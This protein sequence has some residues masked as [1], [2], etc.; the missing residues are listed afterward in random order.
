MLSCRDVFLVF[1]NEPK[2][3]EAVLVGLQNRVDL[4]RCEDVAA[5][6]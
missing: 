5:E 3:L 2:N 4:R 6:H 1:K